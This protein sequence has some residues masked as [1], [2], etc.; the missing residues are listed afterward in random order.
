[1]TNGGAKTAALAV[2]NID[3][4]NI[5]Y[6][7]EAGILAA[8]KSPSETYQFPIEPLPIVPEGQRLE[9]PMG[10]LGALLQ[11]ALAN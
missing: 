1:L 10:L 8:I 5:R 4:L 9:R 11:F 2:Q 7:R 6:W 3:F